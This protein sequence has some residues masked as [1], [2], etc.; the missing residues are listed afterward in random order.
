MWIADTEIDDLREIGVTLHED[1]SRF[2]IRGQGEFL[3]RPSSMTITWGRSNGGLWTMA[4]VTVRG[5]R[6]DNG[7]TGL[8][9][10]YDRKDPSMHTWVRSIID[11]TSP[12]ESW[13]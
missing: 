4:K 7:S 13:S 3:I 11:E 10:W 2:P 9:C 1:A 12:E 8:R 5:L 6:T